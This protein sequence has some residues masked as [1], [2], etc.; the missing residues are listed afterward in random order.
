M[1]ATILFALVRS[2]RR[3][4]SGMETP[5]LLLKITQQAVKLASKTFFTNNNITNPFLEFDFKSRTHHTIVFLLLVFLFSFVVMSL[6]KD[7][8]FVQINNSLD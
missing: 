5:F 7:F 2:A 4:L 8:N 1:L 3:C 6:D